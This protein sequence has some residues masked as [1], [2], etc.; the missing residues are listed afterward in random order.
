MLL[1]VGSNLLLS[2]V[3]EDGRQGIVMACIVMAYI[4]MACIV[5]LCSYGLYNHGTIPVRAVPT[6]VHG[7]HAHARVCVRVPVHGF[8]MPATSAFLVCVAAST[9]IGTFTCWAEP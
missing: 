1:Q 7:T 5:C 6:V 4:V 9:S 8:R 2:A 3:Y